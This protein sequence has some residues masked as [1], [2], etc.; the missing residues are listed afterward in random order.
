VS[1]YFPD[2][3]KEHLKSKAD[4][5]Q[6]IS[7]FIPTQRMGSYYWAK[8][9]FHDD[10]NPSLMIRPD[11]NTFYCMSCAAGS[12]KHSKVQSSDV[13]GFIM[14]YN[15]WNMGEAIEWLARFL[16][17]PLPA[18]D[19]EEQKH[20]TLKNKWYEFCEHAAERFRQNLL[21]K[22]DALD[23]LYQRG[24]TMED[25]LTWKLG[26]GDKVDYD[27]RNTEERIVFSLFDENG[28][29]ISFTGRIPCPDHILKEANERLKAQG[30]PPIRKYLD[31][32]PVKKEDPYYKNHPYPEFD[33]GNHLYGL[34]IAKEY[35]RKWGAA[36][37]VEG[38]TDVIML[39][40]YGA[41]HTVGTMGAALTEM[42]AKLLKRFGAQKV[43]IMRDGD[44][45]GYQAAKRDADILQKFEIAPLIV[46][47]EPGIDPCDLCNQ[48]GYGNKE[49]LNRYINRKAMTL[50]QFQLHMLYTETQDQI[51]YHHAQIAS[52]QNERMRKA[53]QILS[54]IKDPIERDIYVRQVSD[55]FG[56]S[57]DAVNAQVGYYERTK[58]FKVG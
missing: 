7:Q 49:D 58:T 20:V 35:I 52:M 19:P 24:F 46:P 30:K 57:Y 16:G 23:Y 12:K 28:H 34:H 15:N 4:I 53:I 21:N 36:V 44:Q 14:G 55:L 40:K 6:V 43:L 48:F 13:Y 45:A 33:K 3:F 22:K 56:I 41:Q 8:C 2:E 50:N 9:P 5:L 54:T 29:I 38:W 39:H 32:Y 26:F 11:T 25:I 51:L 42:Q 1:R 10:H 18:L 31:R 17:E 27:F 47:L 37:L